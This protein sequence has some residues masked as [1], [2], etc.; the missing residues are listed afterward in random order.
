MREVAREGFHCMS[1]FV[2]FTF[3]KKCSVPNELLLM[4]KII[5]EAVY[6]KLIDE[7]LFP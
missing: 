4:V 2:V 6:L 7:I 3:T 1:A 5:L